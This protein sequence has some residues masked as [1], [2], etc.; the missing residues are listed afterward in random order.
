[1]KIP[2]LDLKPVNAPFEE[3]LK[4]AACNVISSGRYINGDYVNNLEPKLYVNYK[5]E[6]P[7]V[8]PISVPLLNLDEDKVIRVCDN[9]GLCA[10]NIEIEYDN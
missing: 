9:N 5:L 10:S 2:F 6:N 4:K 1:M 8:T 7:E 3:E